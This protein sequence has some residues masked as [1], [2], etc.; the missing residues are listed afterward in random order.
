MLIVSFCFALLMAIFALSAAEN[1]S[2]EDLLLHKSAFGFH[3]SVDHHALAKGHEYLDRHMELVSPDFDHESILGVEPLGGS[4]TSIQFLHID[5]KSTDCGSVLR[6]I[7]YRLDFCV[8]VNGP[9]GTFAGS[10]KYYSTLT[11]GYYR[12]GQ[13]VY[14]TT[15]C[16]GSKFK[17]LMISSYGAPSTCGDLQQSSTIPQDYFN[18]YYYDITNGEGLG[19]LTYKYQGSLTTGTDLGNPTSYG[20]VF[21]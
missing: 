3:S 11:G 18:Y 5:V 4:S 8:L 6:R 13:Y 20:I 7:S 15:D 17:T 2:N 14:K 12:L 10:F 19:S 21:K 9:D 1:S 16:T